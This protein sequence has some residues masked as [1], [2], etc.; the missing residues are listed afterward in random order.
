MKHTVAA[1]ALLLAVASCG[2]DTSGPARSDVIDRQTFVD[3]YVDLRLAAI[4][5]P[6]FRV[7]PQARDE[8]LARHGVDA[9][10][11]VRFADAYGRDLELMNEVWTEIEARVQESSGDATP[12][13]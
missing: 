3:T 8:I 5:T 2:G 6:E 13:N 12:T 7:S 4:E 11:L 1:T 9:E 10:D